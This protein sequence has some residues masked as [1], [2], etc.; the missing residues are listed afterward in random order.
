NTVMG[1][2]AAPTAD[3]L[4]VHLA[5]EATTLAILRG[6]DLLFY[7][8]RLSDE[9]PLSALVHQTAMYHEDRLGGGAFSRL[10]IS[11]GGADVRGLAEVTT[12]LGAQA[13]IVDVRGA[14]AIPDRIDASPE[15]LDTLAAPVGILLRD[16]EAA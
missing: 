13:T 7:R 9:E 11:G 12:R 8:H 3:W 1:A 4:F 5:A 14:A 16:R 10:L 6:R 2:G 15:L